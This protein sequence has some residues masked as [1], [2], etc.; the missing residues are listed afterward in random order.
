S[1]AQLSRLHRGVRLHRKRRRVPRLEELHLMLTCIRCSS[2]NPV[3]ALCC[4]ACGTVLPRLSAQT[5]ESDQLFTLEEGRS[6]PIPQETFDTENL[7]QL[8]MAIEDYLEGEGEAS[9][10]AT[11][12][13]HIRRYF[14]EFSSQG[15][16]HLN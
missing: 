8:R 5:D 6:Y 14:Q 4:H 13:K 2:P 16:T 10:I 15:V 9:Q 11:W 7:A 12:V 1:L 3:S